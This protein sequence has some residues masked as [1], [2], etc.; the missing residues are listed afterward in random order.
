MTQFAFPTRYNAD[1]HIVAR[2]P[3]ENYKKFIFSFQSMSKKWTEQ[4]YVKYVQHADGCMR[5]KLQIPYGADVSTFNVS[6]SM[7]VRALTFEIDPPTAGWS[8]NARGTVSVP[9]TAQ[10]YSGRPDLESAVQPACSSTIELTIP[11]I[12]AEDVLVTPKPVTPLMS[13]KPDVMPDAALTP[14]AALL[15]TP[16]LISKGTVH[17]IP[18]HARTTPYAAKPAVFKTPLQSGSSTPNIDTTKPT[19][20][21][22]STTPLAS[23]SNT[24][25]PNTPKPTKTAVSK[26]PLTSGS[27]TPQI[28][29]A[30]TKP[31]KSHSNIPPPPTH[32]PQSSQRATTAIPKPHI[33]DNGV[34]YK[35]VQVNPH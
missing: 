35:V 26:T 10:E 12:P 27:N 16:L 14:S 13:D 3:N 23:G 9:L 17:N 30:P 25:N 18:A 31:P 7:G 19:K 4:L 32:P 15:P 33:W 6:T 28:P 8:N 1:I 34:L 5:A 29:P 20:V 2:V 11:D 22:V 24:P 21:A